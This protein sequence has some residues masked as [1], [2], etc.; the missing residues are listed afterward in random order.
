MKPLLALLLE[1]TRDTRNCKKT[2]FLKLYC[3]FFVTSRYYKKE[4]VLKG[5]GCCDCHNTPFTK[6]ECD[7]AQK[8]IQKHQPNIFDKYKGQQHKEEKVH[9]ESQ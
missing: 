1:V 8:E 7:K 4:G 6:S 5:C 2:H 9:G 3:L